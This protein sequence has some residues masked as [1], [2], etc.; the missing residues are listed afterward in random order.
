MV[1]SPSTN[2]STARVEG[3]SISPIAAEIRDRPRTYTFRRGRTQARDARP[4]KLRRRRH[5]KGFRGC[6]GAPERR[7]GVD[8]GDC[9]IPPG[10]DRSAGEPCPGRGRL[11][12]PGAGG[13]DGA[14]PGGVAA[15]E[16]QPRSQPGCRPRQE[17]VQHAP[18]PSAPHAR[19]PSHGARA[20][21]RTRA[22]RP[23]GRRSGRSGRV[24][25]QRGPLRTVGADR[26]C[27][28]RSGVVPAACHDGRGGLPR[29]ADR[30]G[31]RHGASERS[32]AS[33]SA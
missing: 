17:T 27:R 33:S 30:R 10:R 7:V 22:P 8:P 1:A 14:R 12:G 18:L 3:L 6:G 25:A 29:R 31:V 16:S 9:E 11:P 23:A 24:R 4:R 28:R 32:S 13:G 2:C 21:H 26:R 20:A 15:G 5:R 19:R